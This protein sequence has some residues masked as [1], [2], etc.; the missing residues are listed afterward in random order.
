M[1]A[2][3]IHIGLHKT[4]TSFLQRQVFSN[5][6]MF[7]TPWGAPLSG[8]AIEYFVLCHPMRFSAQAARADFEAALE[9]DRRIPVISHERLSGRPMLGIYDSDRVADRA[10]ATFPKARILIGIRRQK[11]MLRSLYSE[12]VR[13]GGSKSLDFMVNAGRGAQSYRATFRLD[14]LEFDLMYDLFADRFGARNVLILPQELLA[15]NPQAYFDRLFGFLGAA[16][17]D[18]LPG[19]REQKSQA[20][21]TLRARRRINAV[22]PMIDV[23]PALHRPWW[24]SVTSRGLDLLDASLGRTALGGLGGAGLYRGLE[25]ISD[26]DFSE[27][28]RRLAERTGLDLRA[29][30]YA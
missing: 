8:R 30:G 7:Q 17:T 3:I 18:P 27:S 2:P 22:L 13:Q 14:H 15:E 26:S 28:N 4:A 21:L 29:L 19:V 1:P 23:A 5:T 24:Y 6:Q 10:A 9:D 25:M 16:W 12:Y 20:H 11:H